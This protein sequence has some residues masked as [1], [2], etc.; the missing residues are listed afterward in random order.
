MTRPAPT[1]PLACS[2]FA[3]LLATG[4]AAPSARAGSAPPAPARDG[5]D[6][7]DPAADALPTVTRSVGEVIGNLEQ[8]G[9]ITVLEREDIEKSGARDVPDLLRREAGVF[10]TNDTTN[11]EGYRLELR[12]FNNGSGG[13]SS[14]LVLVDGR[15]V[16][17]A[18]G[19][20]TDWALIPMNEVERIEVVRGPVNAA[21]GDNAQ[22]GVINIITRSGD[23]PPRFEARGRL[24]SYD[25]YGS[26]VFAGGS[27]GP[28][29]ASL[30]A[31]LDKSDGYR[32]RS[33][34]RTHGGTFKL[35]FDLGELATLDLK[36]GYS[37]D[38]RER[39][40]TL[41]WQEIDFLGRR[42]AEPGTDDNFNK[43]RSHFVDGTVRLFLA[44]DVVWKTTAY[45]D[46]RRDRGSLGNVTFAFETDTETQAVGVNN[47]LEVRRPVFGRA[48]QLVIGGDWLYEK[49]ARDSLFRDFAFG[50]PDAPSKA[51]I[52]RETWGLFIQDDFFI[53]DDL[54]LAAG[55]RY[56]HN[57]RDGTDVLAGTE[58][59][60]GDSVVSPRA[61]LTWRV[62]ESGSLYASW[63]RGHRFPNLDEALD[64]LG[65]ADPLSAEESESW[66]VGGKW[67]SERVD[68]NLAFYHLT[69][70]DEILANPFVD[71]FLF[72]SSV[73]VDRVV[74]KGVEFSAIVR[75]WE[76]LEI[77]GSYT[78][79]DVEIRRDTLTML[80]G[81]RL[82][83]I[84]LHRG[85]AGMRV[86]GPC[87]SEA[88]MNANFV[89]SR[90]F[91]NDLGNDF[92]RLD[93]FQVVDA[94]VAWRPQIG[95]HVTLGIEANVYNVLDT[96]YEEIGAL[97]VRFDPVTFAPFR[98]QRF[99][100]S[101]E[102]NF[103]VRM[104]VEVRR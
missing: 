66:E 79:D 60:D 61:S 83:M 64:F 26:S 32:E 9:N 87:S 56:D 25:S 8:A 48:N 58:L 19:A 23:G 71:P 73:N 13:G 84:P 51:R 38:R 39:P 17:E 43:A 12:G 82:P 46:A 69:V 30:F 104:M 27:H 54:I 7:P 37:S 14:T 49:V 88:G 24:G 96:K 65:L 11:P 4:T 52:S 59:D 21:W 3:L 76:W 34:F 74:H 28:V 62:V 81:A 98:Q 91:L 78:Y 72:P 68:A 36:A 77:Y 20:T 44:E 5:A 22:A 10:V 53:L 6:A 90:P 45:Y 103:E 100:P 29:R 99:F 67:R 95:E 40:G 57:S 80:E 35:G 16:N 63:S 1:G 94:H 86:L 89:G 50:T 75:P 42:A 33:D 92:P 2:L 47:Q 15:R 70:R 101:P 85:T 31:N 102:R 41:S 55:V 97:G 18:D 93:A